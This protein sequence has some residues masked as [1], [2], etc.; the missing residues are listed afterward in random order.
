MTDATEL[1]LVRSLCRESYEDF[2]HEFWSTIS[3]EPLLWNWHMTVICKDLQFMA[4][5]VFLR[6]PKL[7]DEVINIPPGTSKSSLCSVLFPPWVWTRMPEAQFICPSYSYD[8]SLDLSSKSRDCVKSEKYKACYPEVVLRADQDTKGFFKNTDGGYRYAV[9]S[10]GT[11]LGFHG[12]FILIDDPIDPTRAISEAEMMMTN[13]WIK[14]TLRGRKTDKRVTPTVLIMQRLHQNDPSAQ[15]LERTNVRHLCIPADLDYEVSPPELA[16]FYV[17][18]LMDPVRLTADILDEER[19]PE[20]LGEY[21]YAGQYG[22][23]PIPAGGGMFKTDLIRTAP[24]PGEFKREVRYWDKAASESTKGAY[25]V[26]VRMAEDY[27]GRFW[28]RNVIRVKRDSFRRERLIKRTAF[29]DSQETIVGLEQEGGSGGKDSAAGTARRLR[30]FRVRLLSARGDKELRADEF[31]VCLNGGLL[32]LPE[33]MKDAHGQWTGWAADYIDE[34]KHFPF[35]KFK[36]QTDASA[37]A[38]T[39]LTSGVRRVGG[40]RRGVTLEYARRTGKRAR[41]SHT[42]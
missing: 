12:H 32:Y 31:S 18:G 36:D 7:H 15:M 24:E 11:V 23:N 41:R 30:G 3:R 10:R 20:G 4:E 27:Q 16:R 1:D 9:G 35:S 28:V 8:L 13:H 22:Q 17:D 39:V 29:K 38:Y 21:G 42:S 14:Q 26:G 34:L 33:H 6:L 2:V 19:S 37:G 5:R 25:T 40:M